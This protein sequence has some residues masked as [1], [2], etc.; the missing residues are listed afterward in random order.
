MYKKSR[1]TDSFREWWT[2][3]WEP[4]RS[5][6]L[7]DGCLEAR[8]GDRNEVLDFHEVI[9]L[10]PGVVGVLE[11]LVLGPGV[12][13]SGGRHPAVVDKLNRQMALGD[14]LPLHR[15]VEF[16]A[17]ALEKG[18]LG[19]ALGIDVIAHVLILLLDG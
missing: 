15:S 5:G 10:R 18:F 3:C 8:I 1:P 4:W 6:G 11:V 12:A 2:A 19:F 13:D 14:V 7:V 17:D 16:L 9:G